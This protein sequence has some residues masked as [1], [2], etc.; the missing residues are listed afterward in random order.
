MGW[1][2]NLTLIIIL[3]IPLYPT[4]QQSSKS[5]H[6]S[7]HH[8]QAS[9]QDNKGIPK[10][11]LENWASNFGGQLFQFGVSV[12]KYNELQARF[13]T[14]PEIDVRP[15]NL[16]TL[17][18]DIVKDMNDNLKEKVDAI[19][20]IMNW[21]EEKALEFYERDPST[22]EKPKGPVY[23]SKKSKVRI[24]DSKDCSDT[25]E[26][27]LCLTPD[28]HFNNYVNT[29]V[30]SVHVPTS[31]F[32][33]KED[34][35]ESIGWSTNMD[36]TF[37]SNYNLNPTL[38]YQYFGSATGFLRHYPAMMWPNNNSDRADPDLYDCR[39]R[40]WYVQ[41]ANSPKNM[42]ILHDVSGSMTGIRREIAKHVVNQLLDTLTE[43][44]YVNVYNFSDTTT[45]VVPC[46]KNRLV[47]ANLENV[48]ELK[49][50]L[51]QDHTAGIAN[52]TSA[53]NTAFD[54]LEKARKE[55]ASSHCNQA[56][57]I[58]TDGAPFHFEEIFK[59]RQNPEHYV[60]VFTYLIGREVTEK[61][62]V[63][64]M[65]C[66]N[67]GYFTHVST[68]SEVQEKVL[69]YMPVMSRPMVIYKKHE[70]AWT[71]VY[72]HIAMSP[73]RSR[74][75]YW[76]LR[77]RSKAQMEEY[78]PPSPKPKDPMEPFDF[79]ISA[80][81]PVFDNRNSTERIAIF[82]GVA[83][84]D[85]PIK[86]LRKI[87]SPFKLGVN[88]YAFMVNNNGYIVFHPDWR[89]VF[90]GRLLKPNYNTVDLTEVEL[91]D[92]DNNVRNNDS[93]LLEMR[94]D[95][96]E[97]ERGY[98][99]G[100]KVRVQ[101]DNFTMAV[102]DVVKDDVYVPYY[103]LRVR[104]MRDDFRR[105]TIRRQVYEFQRVKMI[106]QHNPRENMITP[107]TLAI[108]V[109]ENANRFIGELEIRLQDENI[110]SY[111]DKTN[112][113]RK[114]K[115]NPD[116][117]YC[118]YIRG[119]KTF[120]TKEDLLL[121]FLE[122]IQGAT[123]SWPWRNT[124]IG[125]RYRHQ[126]HQAGVGG[127]SRWHSEAEIYECEKELV[128]SLVFDANVTK[129]FNE[130]NLW[131]FNKN[132]K[133]LLQMNGVTMAFIATRTGLTRWMDF[134]TNQEGPSANP[135]KSSND[136]E[137]FITGNSGAT[138]E[139][140]YKR[141]VERYEHDP[142][143][144]VYT[145]PFD[146]G[147]RNNSKV[148][149]TRAIFV[150]KNG[151]QA[152]VAVV[153]VQFSHA[154]WTK[155]FLDITS[156]QYDSR[157]HGTDLKRNCD[158]GEFDCFVL[159]DN[160]FIL[161]SENHEDTGK[162]FGEVDG[163]VMEMLVNSD[164]YKRVRVVDYQAVC[165][166]A[167]AK[168][169]FASVLSTPLTHVTSLFNWFIAHLAWVIL[170][171]NL[172]SI[173]NP[174][175][176]SVLAEMSQDDIPHR[177]E[178]EEID[179]TLPP[180]IELASIN[181]TRLRPCDKETFLYT[182]GSSYNTHNFSYHGL[183]TKCGHSGCDGYFNVHYIPHTNLILVVTDGRCRCG[184]NSTTIRQREVQYKTVFSKKLE[185]EEDEDPMLSVRPG[186]VCRTPKPT[187]HRK[188]PPVCTNYNPEEEYIREDCGGGS[189][190][191]GRMLVIVLMSSVLLLL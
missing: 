93:M 96:I 109:P 119:G 76:L 98:R 146:A 8:A 132:D 17:I 72:A 92:R 56:I 103:K 89:P 90:N 22:R 35:L 10:Q 86:E 12:T 138:N 164:V 139:L 29:N 106:N 105:V 19:K 62:E 52:F 24:E 133:D 38:S 73:I 41:A 31:I 185:P 32:E 75:T 141:A 116:W 39:T 6:S 55:A 178:E 130:M 68:L 142:E 3:V 145:V 122:K 74:R 21:A 165:L 97:E 180:Y 11:I 48:R 45:P 189:R 91:V 150:K 64:W 108:A 25:P 18:T 176:A 162:F 1:L 120:E 183:L 169:N 102:D 114:W 82:L 181:K 168:T 125:I 87:A 46:L 42:F 186:E 126:A 163:M 30:S 16:A 147:T 187:L 83:G 170:Q 177:V 171:L 69:K 135:E 129:I 123:P 40:P 148:T 153:G 136:T 4:Y 58:I 67:R 144:F 101:Q 15:M 143:S 20:K 49:V 70:E 151:I 54:V 33:E 43:N 100:L 14:A 23:N 88:G 167:V 160:G 26:D 95:M 110:L 80:S 173:V 159:D 78:Y 155:R 128:Q 118:E 47:Q 9:K 94:N 50:G 157:S 127:E 2:N 191:M 59:N 37:L 175:Y 104:K 107:Y 28:D 137:W 152:P 188:R 53:L 7:H 51:E 27:V 113:P 112:E 5:Q 174:D 77:F 190:G 44:D 65:A 161:V 121:H 13:S 117:S 99:K 34:V 154:K 140:W 179:H 81:V 61:R 115:I 158:N 36:Q 66:A 84:T 124:R 172:H 111:F 85:I 149:A 57:M 71:P 131:K 156:G 166:Q 63:L 134:T 60:R 184:L 79:V 182:Y